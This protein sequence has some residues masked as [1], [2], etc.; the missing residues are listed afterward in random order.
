MAWKLL[1]VLALVLCP[2]L[3]SASSGAAKG[4]AASV[5]GATVPGL[6]YRFVAISPNSPYRAGASRPRASGFTVLSRIDKRG[7]RVH[8]WWYLP[9]H[10]SIPSAAFDDRA[11]GLSA[12]GSTL[13][14]DRFSWIYPP[15]STRLA[16]VHTE[17]QPR[18][19][20]GE[21]PPQPAIERLHLSGSFSFDAISPDG[22]TVYLIEHLSRLFGG[23]YQVRA[24]D[25]SSG[26]LD[27][28]PIVDPAEPMERMEGIPISRAYSRDGRWAYTLYTSHQKGKYELA[29]E[30][31]VH[32]LDTVSGEAVCIDLPQLEGRPNR[33]LLRLRAERNG[34]EL[35]VFS[36]AQVRQRPSS[37]P[38]L[39][40]D[41]RSFEVRRPEPVAAASGGV[42]ALPPIA[43]LGVI[44]LALA[45]WIGRR[46]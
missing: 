23:A 18:R 6:P 19:A 1:L 35:E 32:A 12:D 9:G 25:V 46:R 24:L 2:G 10:Y 21:G 31:F 11:G 22:S 37:P 36:K 42:G 33:F 17:R 43:A 38:L 16:I 14:L 15:R 20:P 39:T 7:G 26:E 40:V 28:V 27:P 29:H 41:T 13:V 4:L 30:P 5:Q 45:A 44:G 34:R 8:R 3:A